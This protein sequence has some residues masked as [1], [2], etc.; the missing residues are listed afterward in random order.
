M[1]RLILIAVASMTTWQ[2]AHAAD[3][4][5]RA[6]TPSTIKISAEA[7]LQPR[8]PSRDVEAAL[9]GEDRLASL[10]RPPAQAAEQASD[11]CMDAGA[12]LCYDARSRKVIYKPMRKLLP[13]I[14]G[15]TPHN[16]TL[17]RN[18]I[19]ASYTFQ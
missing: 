8:A 14:P 2:S 13:E 6:S 10:L 16:L 7:L 3:S 9:R 19:T 18:K 17:G 12:F 11:R 4:L 1:N 5:Y 15:M